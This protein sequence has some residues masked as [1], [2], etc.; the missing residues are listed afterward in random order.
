MSN[1]DLSMVHEAQHRLEI[2]EA[3]ALQVQQGVLMWVLLEDCAEK[4]RT[5]RK[6]E[7]MSLNLSGAT[8]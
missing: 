8:A 5:C 2:I 4:R 6:D 3:D 1:I 7:F